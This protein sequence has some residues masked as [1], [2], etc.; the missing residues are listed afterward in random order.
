MQFKNNFGFSL[1]L[2]LILYLFKIILN[3]CDRETP[4]LHGRNCESLFCSDDQYSS[5]ECEINNN[6]IKTQWLNNVI[7]IGNEYSTFTLFGRYSNGDI[8][9]FV[10]DNALS[11]HRFFYG[12]KKN[13]RPLFTDTNNIETP[14]KSMVA[15]NAN[16][17]RYQKEGCIITTNSDKKE[18][19][20]SIAK[21]NHYAELYDFENNII[22]KKKIDEFAGVLMYNIIGFTMNRQEGSNDYS[23]LLGSLIYKNHDRKN[24]YSFILQKFVINSKESMENDSDL[25]K[26]TTSELKDIALFV[27]CFETTLKNIV[28]FYS[29]A[30]SI[31]N[32][33]YKSY[34]IIAYD[35]NLL[36][37]NIIKEILVTTEVEL[38]LFF[39]CLHI[40]DEA[41]L[42]FYY[43][44]EKIYSALY[45]PI[46]TFKNL[47]SS[48]F[49]DSFPEINEIKLDFHDLETDELQN[50][51]VKLSENSFVFA[52]SSKSHKIIHLFM[53]N[54]FQN[55]G[56]K[57][58]IR[59][60]QINLELFNFYFDLS[61]KVFSY[62]ELLLLSF[63]FCYENCENE[64]TLHYQANVFLSY[65]N[66]TDV[67]LNI[68]D[69]LIENNFVLIDFSKNIIIQNNVFGLVFS[70][71]LI[72][73]FE[74]CINIDFN[75]SIENEDIIPIYGL[76][77]NESA[78]AKLSFV[79]HEQINC[80]IEYA[81][82]VTEPD[83]NEYDNYPTI[84]N[85]TFGDDKDI[86]DKL[87]NKYEG[88]T[89]YYFLKTSEKLTN[90]CIDNNCGLCLT[91]KNTCIV[92]KYNFTIDKDSSGNILKTCLENLNKEDQLTVTD[93][94][95]I[96]TDLNKEKTDL[97]KEET[98]L[99]KQETDLKK[100]ETDL[101][102]QET[103]LIKQE[104]DLIKQETDLK[105]V[106]TD[107]IK[108]DTDLIKQET[109]LN[110]E[111]TDLNKENEKE[112]DSIKKE[113]EIS[114]PTEEII[115]IEK[116][117]EKDKEKE[118][119]E[120]ITE[121]PNP[122]KTCNNNEIL[123]N[124]CHDGTMTNKQFNELSKEIEKKYIN[125]ETYHLENTIILTG[126]VVFQISKSVD[127]K[128]NTY[129]NISNIDLGECESKI[130]KKFSIKEEDSLI[131][132]KQ[133]IRIE[134]LATTYVQYKVYHPYSL[135]LLNL[136]LCSEDEISISVPVKLQEETLSL[137]KS[138]NE[139]GYNLFDSNDAFYND[140]CTPYTTENGTDISL[141]D[142]KEIVAEIGNDLNLCQTGCNLKSYDSSKNKATCI[143][144]VE[145]TPDV[146]NFD[147]IG[148]ES[149]IKDFIDTLKY[150]NYLVLKCYKLISDFK[151]LKENIG[152]ILISIIFISFLI[153]AFIFIF[154]GPRKIE[155][156]IHSILKMKEELFK[157]KNKNKLI[158]NKKKIICS[159]SMPLKHAKKIK[160]MLEEKKSHSHK[161]LVFKDK[162]INKRKTKKGS[163]IFFE[164]K[165]R[166]KYKSKKNQ[167]KNQPPKKAKNKEEKYS[168]KKK[169]N[170]IKINSKLEP[171]SGHELLSIDHKTKI[172]NLSINILPIEHLKYKN[173]N[174]SI[175]TKFLYEKTNDNDLYKISKKT[176]KKVKYNEKKEK[177][178]SNKY[179][180]NDN[181]T[182][183]SVKE[184]N[185]LD[186]FEAI[187][188]DKRT[189]FQYYCSLIKIKQVFLFTFASNDDYNLFV[190]K[191]SLLLISF[192]LYMVVDA[193]FF[194]M[195]KMH[196]IYSKN[197][198][199]DLIL[200]MP[201]IIY[202]S[203]ICS[204]I[205]SILKQL[206]LFE[207]DILALKKIEEKEILYR[208]AKSAKKCLIIKSIIFIF[209]SLILISFF[210]YYLS[211]FCA[212]Y[213]NTQKILLK[214]AIL[215]FC[216]SMSYSFGIC[217]L[218]GFFRIPAL[219]AK[220]HDKEGL[221]KFSKILSFI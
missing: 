9:I 39:K 17:L 38:T 172:R 61:I 3:S 185:N 146:I 13:G 221:Y 83:C 144:F 104:T 170:R 50:D 206:S 116:T 44:Y 21:D 49:I 142:R 216:L 197:G 10:E 35:S 120:K 163:D 52:G 65:P 99:I 205:N 95:K 157:N 164:N 156:F 111:Q 204:L 126:N 57:I 175:N 129:N 149:V 59:F 98:D 194:S 78:I 200:Q 108:Q 220:N 46:F 74:N 162:I 48:E 124:T 43:F 202:S 133:D 203:L 154:T 136:S 127:Q 47:T 138:L 132:Y 94:S 63:N 122:I 19:F 24:T 196:E 14:F 16:I 40:K 147:N 102:K 117:N 30:T 153:L 208:K 27:S 143:C 5:G 6:I 213:T 12:L 73:N 41:G 118:K 87:K 128:N 135:E 198:A 140:I 7:F 82:E 103:D 31:D 119:T 45:Y 189:F 23:F 145:K 180:I 218:P 29:N 165:K 176:N 51:L 152:F 2:L 159:R 20:L 8:L 32:K 179:L 201:Q 212:V 84:I 169:N 96:E 210:S 53:I 58:K 70:S 66:S 113:E 60:Y 62:N 92:C 161:K 86:F 131:I 155:Y 34:I 69:E 33:W 214:D 207:Y 88:K 93:I 75:S 190:F 121:K 36:E 97:K 89:S 174:K 173:I 91:D 54:I 18:Y 187:K 184:L 199:Y 188:I 100:E 107:L 109:D 80:K 85:T 79:E 11:P 211:C 217:L 215:S 148:V 55:N 56:N 137:Y 28:C 112:S 101:I 76:K 193:L 25:L 71:I 167:S 125:N 192:S 15:E 42:F 183:I 130:K 150:S 106:D 22:Y 219:R 195:D 67:S 191:F 160:K 1:R 26:Y 4:I 186:Y 110:K 171:L 141:N 105:N 90:D 168:L 64:D 166:K 81:Y 114:K 151:K 37:T 182:N 72:K 139:S 134:N 77:R 68:I 181:H 178:N 123:N 115:N 158:V 177:N 209:L